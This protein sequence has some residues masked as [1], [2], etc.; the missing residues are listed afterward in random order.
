MKLSGLVLPAL[1]I[2]G[3]LLAGCTQSPLPTVT[4]SVTPVTTTIPANPAARPSFTLGDIYFN[5]PYGTLFRNETTVVEQSFIVDD[6]SWGIDLKVIP[7]N[8][9]SVK[10][11]WFVIDV[12]NTNTKRTDSFGYGRN[13]SFIDQQMIPMYNQGPYKITMKGNQVK[14]WVTVAKRNP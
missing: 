1:V 11:S 6:P 3:V 7:T 10:N 4:P 2:L 13:F 12:T 8:N 14:V 9:E 5:N